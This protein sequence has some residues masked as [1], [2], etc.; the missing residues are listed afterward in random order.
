[1]GAFVLRKALC[2]LCGIVSGI[3]V[4]TIVGLLVPDLENNFILIWMS[5]FLVASI[6]ITVKFLKKK[7][8]LFSK[9]ELVYLRETLVIWE[10]GIVA[11]AFFAVVLLYHFFK[12]VL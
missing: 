3:V 12:A 2:W 9:E 5:L 8:E 11:E 6:M 4:S 7:E 1:M 10:L